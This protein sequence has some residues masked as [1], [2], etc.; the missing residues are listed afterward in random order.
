MTATKQDPIRSVKLTAL[1]KRLTDEGKEITDSIKI[2]SE[3]TKNYIIGASTAFY[4]FNHLFRMLKN[5]IRIIKNKVKSEDGLE[6]WK[7]YAVYKLSYKMIPDGFMSIE[8]IMMAKEKMSSMQF[9]MEYNCLFPSESGG[10]YPA[11]VVL[12]AYTH[13]KKIRFELV[14]DENSSYVLFCDAARTSD[15]CT[16]AISKILSTTEAIRYAGVDMEV[17]Q[18]RKFQEAAA[19]IRDLCRRFH[20][21]RIAIDAGGGGLAIKDLLNDPDKCPEGEELIYDFEDPNSYLDKEE[22]K[23]PKPGK[24]ILHMVNFNPAYLAEA[25]HGL[26]SSLERKE[27]VFPTP[28]G[29]EDLFNKTEKEAEELEEAETEMLNTKNEIINIV[30]TQTMKGSPHWDTP[31]KGQRKDRYTAILGCCKECKDFIKPNPNDISTVELPTGGWAGSV[32][33][34][35]L[36]DAAV[37][38]AGELS[39]GD[40]KSRIAHERKNSLAY[41][42]KLSEI[43]ELN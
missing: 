11:H 7:L 1:K 36:K 37:L 30:L 17:I 4:Q 26:L 39:E 33:G 15:N 21:V 29:T 35:A 12:N 31:Q 42:K 8:S 16:F 38:E 28:L 6:L 18:N 27:Y 32:P 41:S 9:N 5:H 24:H 23:F 10:F 34:K 19:K 3:L 25:N 14:G 40:L 13:E 22:M 20:V 43:A 2:F